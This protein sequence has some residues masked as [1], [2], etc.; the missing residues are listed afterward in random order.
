M[1]SYTIRRLLQ[2]LVV[3]LIV[4]WFTFT[5]QYWQPGG[6]L[7]PVYTACS[8]HPY[9]ACY[10]PLIAAHGLNHGYFY[11]LGDY[12]WGIFWHHSLGYSFK[13]SQPVTKYLAVYI[14]RTFWLAF[15]SVLFSTIIAIP[16]GIYQAWKRNTIFD[17]AVTGIGFV[18]YATPAFIMAILLIDAF[19]IHTPHFPV[20][21][22]GVDAW[23]LFSQPLAFV[24]PVLVLTLLQVAGVSRFMRSQVIDVLVQDFIRTARAKGCSNAQVLFRHTFR[25]A[26]GP[27][28]T[29]LGLTLP[30]LLSGALIVESV[31]NYSGIGL[32]TV[33]ASQNL[34]INVVLG[35]TVVVT[36]LTILGNLLADLGLALVNPR[37]RLE[38]A[39]R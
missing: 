23:A 18:L 10:D 32:L 3:F 14:P 1:L 34:D 25:N 26:I 9:P 4:V 19:I 8:L 33:Q 21:P 27:I 20:P 29:I 36:V 30:A 6:Y 17:Y 15:F 12:I 35:I 37:I 22:S 7:A 16:L 28:V 24:I 39:V 5:L 38:G 11:R 13:E 31:F 2:G